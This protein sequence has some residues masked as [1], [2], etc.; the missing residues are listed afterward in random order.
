MS[1]VSA[2]EQGTSPAPHSMSTIVG[3][4]GW[5]QKPASSA[6]PQTFSVQGPC[7][8]PSSEQGKPGV[9]LLD[10]QVPPLSQVSGSEHSAS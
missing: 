5:V 4:G 6:E 8:P 9:R 2:S 1:Q 10:R 7:L 3:S